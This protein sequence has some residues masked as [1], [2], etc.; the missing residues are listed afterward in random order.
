MVECVL[1][2]RAVSKMHEVPGSIPGFSIPHTVH[3]FFFFRPG[4]LPITSDIENQI[5]K[6]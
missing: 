6:K 1:S 3:F 2:T 5:K 4:S